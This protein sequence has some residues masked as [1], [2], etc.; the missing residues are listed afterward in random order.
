[1]KL[2]LTLAAFASCASAQERVALFG[3]VVNRLN[4]EPVRR[5]LVK[6]YQGK[7]EWFELSDGEG[8]YRF[9]PLKRAE[10]ELAIHRD[11]FT[12]RFYK[13]EVSD[14]DDP[15][16]LLVE[17]M[18]QGVVAGK[19]V[20][21]LGQPIERAEIQALR[22]EQIVGSQQTNDLGEYR[23]SGLDAG[24]YRI[25]ASYRGGRE[26]EFDSTPITTASVTKPG[27]F[28]VK[29]GAIIA[30]I[31]FELHPVRPATIHGII[32]TESG[33]PVDNARLW[34]DKLGNAGSVD[35]GKFVISDVSPGTYVISARTSDNNPRT[36][37]VKV[38]VQGDDVNGVDL[39]LR[40]MPRIEGLIQMDGSEIPDLSALLVMF[41]PANPME[42]AR[43]SEFGRPDRSG[44]F[45]A[46]LNPG[47]YVVHVQR[48]RDRF[49]VKRIILDGVSVASLKVKVDSQ[50]VTRKLVIVLDPKIQP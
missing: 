25:R 6:I 2:W 1:M 44:A 14:F 16:E 47:E 15:K 38:D 7:Q 30:G 17:L 8:R 43:S 32:H 13:V 49:A 42:I 48:L 40:P 21:G 24:A 10:Y 34:T 3:R 27:E 37:S 33:E 41:Q 12:D 4:H 11:G 45:I 20:D 23:L 31:D 5:A 35:H 36:G 39:T 26:S 29:P 19:V 28:S 50:A 18:P 9:P 46:G 22:G